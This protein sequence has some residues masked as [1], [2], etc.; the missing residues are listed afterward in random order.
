MAASQAG[1]P[2]AAIRARS[3]IALLV[4]AAA[5]G[6][7]IACVAYF[8]LK[9]TAVIQTWAFQDLPMALSDGGVPRWWPVVPLTVAGLLVALTIR[10][11]PG[12]GGEVPIEGFK[13][14]ATPMPAALPGIAAAAVV[15]IGLGVVI[16]PEGPLVA[17]GAG[18]AAAAVR[19]VKKA[20][21]QAGRVVGVS[22]SF[23]AIST[24]LGNPLGGA[25]LLLEAS[26]LGGPMA[27]AVLVP[28]LLSAGIGALIFTGLDSFT[29]FGSFALAIPDLPA[30]GTPTVA[31]L[32]YAVAAGL[33]GAGL[34]WV[35]RRLGG[36]VRT[37]VDRRLITV[38][39]A[40]GLA[41]AV[42][43][44]AYAQVTGHSSS[45][46]LFS[47]QSALPHLVDHSSSYTVGA[48]LML[49]VCKGLAYT[50]ALAAFRGGPTFPAMFIGAAGG[51][52]ASHLPGL[53]LIA[54]V[55]IGLGAMTVG[56][57]RLPFTAVL[58]TSIFLGQDS[59]TVIPLTIVSVVV[60]YVAT[61]HLTPPVTAPAE[62]AP[63]ATDTRTG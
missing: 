21:P 13:A 3:Y 33:V 36:V 11:L 46:V 58:L 1:D 49:V 60:S 8:F 28:G 5:L 23:A 26:G 27:A 12:R 6:V 52:A 56:M 43:A 53:S 54:A 25:L 20:P 44:I 9:L 39:V 35:I 40:V 59:Y 45:D 14:G 10:Y 19:L 41:I 50:G 34:C 55:A 62:P 15:G 48:A 63:P 51:V 2:V 37:A 16:G 24:L 30:A 29:G 38:T 4:V 47:G 17:L 18:L 42:L 32:G 57:L 7:P 31:E 22:G 61:T